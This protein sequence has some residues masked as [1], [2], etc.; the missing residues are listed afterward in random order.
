MGEND[1]SIFSKT[2]SS[3]RFHGTG[4][5]KVW[6]LDALIFEGVNNDLGRR[7]VKQSLGTDEF[8]VKHRIFSFIVLVLF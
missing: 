5:V 4:Q 8:K 3:N 2:H 6:S 7:M 1:A